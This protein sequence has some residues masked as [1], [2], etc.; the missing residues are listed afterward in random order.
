MGNATITFFFSQ[1]I[2]KKIQHLA[3]TDKV[4]VINSYVPEKVKKFL[5]RKIY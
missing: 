3:F 5:L 4:K 2:L 1:K